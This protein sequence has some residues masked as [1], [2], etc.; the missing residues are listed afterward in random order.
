MRTEVPVAIA[1]VAGMLMIVSLFVPHPFIAEPAAVTRSWAIII[2]AFAYVLGVANIA[3]ISLGTVR[4]RSKDWEYKAVL[5]AALIVM[6]FLG[7]GRGVAS[8]GTFDWAYQN[9]YIPM[10]ATMFS[11]LAF[12]IASAAY[13]AFRARSAEATLLLVTAAIVML[14]R[15]PVGEHIWSKFPDLTE[16]IMEVPNMAAKRG[17]MIGAA[18]GAISTGLKMV[19]G[20]ERSYLGGG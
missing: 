12:F 13:R 14:G 8:G 16:W 10:Q 6:I 18:L 20:L 19:L 1:F 2:T 3:R 9:L 11:L 15:V 4:K 7:I 17:I 5:L